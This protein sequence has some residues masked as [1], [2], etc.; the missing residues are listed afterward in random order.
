MP[1]E[2]A[3]LWESTQHRFRGPPRAIADELRSASHHGPPSNRMSFR[4]SQ[5]M[6]SRQVRVSR[7]DGQPLN[8][9]LNGIPRHVSL[10]GRHCALPLRD[11]ETSCF[12]N[13]KN[14]SRRAGRRRSRWPTAI[15]GHE[16]KCGP[17]ETE[18]ARA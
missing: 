1:K 3:H 10:G 18:N 6:S 15:K 4:G 13:E 2:R 8:L 9:H 11:Y 16:A 12:L 5:C 14:G 7:L 17:L